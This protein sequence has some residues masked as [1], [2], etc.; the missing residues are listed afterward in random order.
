MIEI[1]FLLWH[2]ALMSPRLRNHRHDRQRQRHAVHVK[3]LQ[4][5]VQ[6]GRI[7]SVAVDDRKDLIH[8]VIHKLG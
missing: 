7:R 6:H 4:R 8:I 3:K 1:S 2:I 5:I